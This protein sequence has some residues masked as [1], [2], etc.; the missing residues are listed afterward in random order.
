MTNPP[1]VGDGPD[2]VDQIESEWSRE[3]PDV[4]VSSIGIVTRIWRV[5][6]HLERERNA[7][8]AEWGADRAVV[9]IL[10]MLRRSGA[11][12]IRSA[13]DLS[14]HAL[15]TSGGVSQRLEKLEK[16]GL[17]VRDVDTDDRRRVLVQLTPVGAQLI[18]SVLADVVHR[19]NDALSA[20][21]DVHELDE[22][23]VLLR[24]LLTAFES[25]KRLG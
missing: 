15:I 21:L 9:D 1:E 8:L 14:E 6:R 20:A 24:K 4:D 11:P 3:R 18:D 19:E 23:R 16:A 10:G 12:Y 17:V 5:G 2:G 22:L 25:P 13:G 7:L